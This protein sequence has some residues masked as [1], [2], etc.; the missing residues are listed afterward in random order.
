M[1]VGWGNLRG[2]AVVG[3]GGNYE[4]IFGEEWEGEGCVYLRGMGM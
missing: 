2:V 3:S 1:G 4:G